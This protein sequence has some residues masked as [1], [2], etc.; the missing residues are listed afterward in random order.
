[1]HALRAV[2]Q[3]REDEWWVAGM[4]RDWAMNPVRAYLAA[5]VKL[6]ATLVSLLKVHF[7]PTGFE[8]FFFLLAFLIPL[9]GD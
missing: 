1:M 7:Y 6:S 2:A 9:W 4:R 5:K 3:L 8:C